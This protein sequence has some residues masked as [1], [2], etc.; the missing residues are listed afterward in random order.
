[1]ATLRVNKFLPVLAAAVVLVFAVVAFFASR[2]TSNVRMVQS[3]N[4]VRV[5]PPLEADADTTADTIHS[6]AGMV[7]GL[8]KNVQAVR[9]ENIT[10]QNEKEEIQKKADENIQQL[11][12]AMSRQLK[13]SDASS[14]E[15]VALLTQQLDEMK[16]QLFDLK[17][18]IENAR[19]R[20]EPARPVSQPGGLSSMTQIAFD[21]SDIEVLPGLG[22]GKLNSGSVLPGTDMV[23]FVWINPLDRELPT[24][25]ISDTGPDQIMEYDSPSE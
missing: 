5:T 8:Q 24:T 25:V 11:K 4:T 13:Q 6:L 10:L 15:V 16:Q 9:D 17:G 23:D 18:D 3:G 21:T 12:S 20:E 22:M 19:Y 14:Q 1:M 2:D 7:D